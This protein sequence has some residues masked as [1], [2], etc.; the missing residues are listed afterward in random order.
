MPQASF[1]TE[2]I[3]TSDAATRY[4]VTAN[5][6]TQLARKGAI[7]ALKFGRDWII[8][9]SSLRAYLATP[10]KPGPKTG[11]HHVAQP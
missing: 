4:R 5:Y 7:R 8:D 10:Q 9:E 11:T 1:F 6:I 2:P 3:S